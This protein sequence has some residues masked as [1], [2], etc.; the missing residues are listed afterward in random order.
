[1]KS[2]LNVSD[3]IDE[4]DSLQDAR[5]LTGV[6]Q[7]RAICYYTCKTWHASSLSIDNQN[8]SHPLVGVQASSESFDTVIEASL[9][10]AGHQDATNREREPNVQQFVK[11][12][13]KAR[14]AP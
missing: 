10:R 11:K 1:M 9:T 14:A 2:S 7:Y 13:S 3:S 6:P 8:Y 12:I 4:M 5:D